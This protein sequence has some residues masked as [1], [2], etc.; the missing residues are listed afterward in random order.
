VC[1]L[2]NDK[3]QNASIGAIMFNAEV[4]VFSRCLNVADFALAANATH[5]IVI[6]WTI[7]HVLVMARGRTLSLCYLCCR[8]Y[9]SRACNPISCVCVCVCGAF[10]VL[11][12]MQPWTTTEWPLSVTTVTWPL[13]VKCIDAWGSRVSLCQ[14]VRLV[15]LQCQRL[16]DTST[17]AHEHRSRTNDERPNNMSRFNCHVNKKIKQHKT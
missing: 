1:S 3:C 4:N 14:V 11:I 9:Y 15:R 6:R 7:K 2:Q 13:P 10:V 17:F 16:S 12:T 5:V 8:G